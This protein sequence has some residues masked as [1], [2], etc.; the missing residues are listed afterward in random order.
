MPQLIE[1]IDAI[2]RKKQRDVLYLEFRDADGNP[3]DHH[4][5]PLRSQIIEWLDREGIG[6]QPCGGIASEHRIRAY[7]GQVYIDVPFAPADPG[8]Q[9]VQAYLE[10]PDGSMRFREATFLV[11]PLEAALCNAHH[12]E[13][14]FWERWAERF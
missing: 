11:L 1:H 8:Y 5:L 9:K 12:D 2:A 7:T 13:P 14:G 10:H 3:V 4:A 6:W